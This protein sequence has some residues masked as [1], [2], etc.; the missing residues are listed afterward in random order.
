M[1]GIHDI[2]KVFFIEEFLDVIEL[3]DDGDVQELIE[4]HH[5]SHSEDVFLDP[6]LGL[7]ANLE[8]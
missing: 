2:S 8:F 6:V 4:R 1:E 5:T 3:D 7:A